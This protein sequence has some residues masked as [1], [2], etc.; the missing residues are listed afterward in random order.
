MIQKLSNYLVNIFLVLLGT[1]SLIGAVTELAV[2]QN[3]LSVTKNILF[4]S[5][6]LVIVCIFIFRKQVKNLVE[7][8]CAS[9]YIFNVI[10]LVIFCGLIFYQLNMIQALTGI[11][12]FDPAFIYSLILHKPIVGSS[13]FSWYPNLLLL[14]NIENVVYHL[15]DNPNIYFFLKSLNVINLFLIDAGLMLIFLILNKQLNKKYAFITLLMA[16]LIFGLTPYIAIPYSDNWA[17]FLMSIYIFLLSTI[18]NKKQFHFNIIPIIFIGIDSA[19]LYKMKPSTIIVLIATIVVLFV[20]ILSKG[21]QYLNFQNIKKQL[22]I[23]FLFIMPFL[24]TISTCDYFVDNNNLIKIEKNSSAGPLHFMA[25]GL[26]GDGGYWWDFN[27]K[28][29]SLP[30]KDR[31]GYEIKVIKKDIRDFGTLNNFINFLIKKQQ[32]NSSLGSW[33]RETGP[34]TWNLSPKL[35][36]KNHFQSLL[37]KLFV[38]NEYFQWNGALVFIQIFWVFVIAFMI[39]S[40]RCSNSFAQLLK[41]TVVGGYL[42]LLLFEGG[43]SRYMIQYLPVV[44]VLS[45][46]GMK[47]IFS[48]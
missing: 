6:V 26:H 12:E 41:Y 11:M 16:I 9:K 44:L 21:K 37:R 23:L 48:K 1:I 34:V 33:Q 42:F 10:F 20:T 25:M 36:V 22:L 14:L 32:K 15:L 28:D 35:R 39:L 18:Y 17:F 29:E 3:K 31:K 47:K 38:Q 27:S 19:L 46:Y 8:C 7:L 13:Y 40:Y 43:T 2:M 4:T 30:P 5:L 24:L 45:S